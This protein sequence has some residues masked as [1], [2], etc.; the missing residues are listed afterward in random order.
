[1][2]STNKCGDLFRPCPDFYVSDL[3]SI[4]TCRVCAEL[5]PKRLWKSLVEVMMAG[6][7]RKREKRITK[8]SHRRGTKRAHHGWASRQAGKKG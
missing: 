8:E 6:R 5:N 4:A 2:S 7:T 1:M 3:H